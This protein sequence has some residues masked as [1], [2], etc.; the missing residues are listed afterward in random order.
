MQWTAPP[1]GTGP[2]QF[3]LVQTLPVHKTVF[4]IIHAVWIIYNYCPGMLQF[5][6]LLYFGPTNGVRCWKR[7]LQV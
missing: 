7:V 2:I 5:K 1:E 4:T 3:A 6:S